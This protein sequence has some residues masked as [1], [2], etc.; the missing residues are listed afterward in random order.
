MISIII[1]IIIYLEELFATKFDSLKFYP[2]SKRFKKTHLIKNF[3]VFISTVNRPQGR[4][5]SAA[6]HYEFPFQ[7][8]S[9][10]AA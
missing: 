10:S 2:F 1:I 3:S 4:L 6:V 9:G 8:I 5:F 7:T